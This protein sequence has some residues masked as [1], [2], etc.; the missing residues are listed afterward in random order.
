ML[1]TPAQ[2]IAVEWARR[3]IYESKLRVYDVK[4]GIIELPRIQ[5]YLH[6]NISIHSRNAPH[7]AFVLDYV[8]EIEAGETDK[9]NGWQNS[10]YEKVLKQL[11]VVNNRYGLTSFLISQP[12]ESYL[13]G[14]AGKSSGSKGGNK[15]L[16]LCDL[17]LETEYDNENA[18]E[19][20]GLVAKRGRYVGYA[21][22][23]YKM[24]PASGL[25][26][27]PNEGMAYKPIEGY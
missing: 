5:S 26:I 21:K 4:A 2:N 1:R 18:P 8:Q 19:D 23:M 16:Q 10:D 14:K 20:L 9:K 12:N 15:L 7:H 25:I 3:K 22:E 13:Q 27:N 11:G 6:Q 24:V 17:W